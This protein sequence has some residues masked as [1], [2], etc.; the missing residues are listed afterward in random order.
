MRCSNATVIGLRLFSPR[1]YPASRRWRSRRDRAS[2]RPGLRGETARVQRIAANSIDAVSDR[3][4]AI[5]FTAA[6]AQIMMHLWRFSEELLFWSS[7]EF[8]FITIA[9]AFTTGSSI[10]PQRKNL[11]ASWHVVKPGECTAVY[12]APYNHERAPTR[13]Q[14][15][16]AG[17]QRA[18]V[19]RS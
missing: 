4:F 12:G 5:E 8:G 16:H 1:E 11:T 17:R 6:C 2:H 19:R 7:S 15:R 9:D 18:S 13:I 3:D 10:M 14:S